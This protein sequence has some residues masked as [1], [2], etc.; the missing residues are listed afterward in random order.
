MTKLVEGVL[1]IVR[2][3]NRKDRKDLVQGLL[4]AGVLSDDDQDRMVLE[5][6]RKDRTRPLNDFVKDMKRKGRHR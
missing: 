1:T 2:G 6:R 4:S 5:S 3:L